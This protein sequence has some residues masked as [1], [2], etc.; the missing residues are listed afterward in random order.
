MK[1]LLTI[2]EHSPLAMGLAIAFSVSGCILVLFYSGML[3]SIELRIYDR[4]LQ[5][6]A[7]NQAPSQDITI[8]EITEQDIRN[9]GAWPMSDEVLAQALNLLLEH[10]PKVIG[11]DLYRD[12][13]VPPGS[14]NLDAVLSSDSRVIATM[15]FSEDA[16]TRIPPPEILEDSIHQV[17]FTDMPLDRDGVVRRGLLFMDEGESTHFSFPLQIA[18]KYLAAEGIVPEPDPDAPEHLRLGKETI[19][20][21]ESSDGGYVDADAGGYQFLLDY[22]GISSEF[23]SY[24]LTDLINGKVPAEAVH[25]KAVLIGVTAQSLKDFF[26]IPIDH[27]S[28]NSRVMAGVALNAHAVSQLIRFA[29]G[30]SQALTTAPNW[31]EIFWLFAWSLAG[32]FAGRRIN[33]FGRLVFVLILGVFTL[34]AITLLLFKV[35]VW[36]PVF[37]PL[38]GGITS[39]GI[40]SAIMYRIWKMRQSQL[41]A[42]FS[43]HISPELAQAMWEERERFLDNK[44]PRPQSLTATVLFTDIAGYTSISEKL[45]PPMLIEWLGK[46]MEAMT[47]AVMDNH[48]I[49]NKY[50]GDAVMAIFGVPVPSETDEEIALNAANA[51]AC[52]AAMGKHCKRLNAMWRKK[53]LPQISIR[54]GIATGELVAGPFGS[55]KRAE[56]SVIGD[57]VNTAARLESLDKDEFQIDY[58]NN[59]CRILITEETKMHLDGC[60]ETEFKGSI[61]LKG[62]ESKTD[63][64]LVNSKN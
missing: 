64:H 26:I 23:M 45:D 61:R 1:K 10:D 28:A 24:S 5:R 38:A 40:V 43:Q 50:M 30:K 6:K 36:I 7:T 4:L 53:G 56:Y 58:E 27:G 33:S 59:P 8:I 21:F 9:L 55:L 22:S 13:P 44:L 20:P 52:A 62:K 39:A 31:V 29:K 18:L 19:V 11:V 12:I 2:I 16:R 15:K 60:W 17:G 35:G 46:N 63:V 48:G 51:V 47:D 41:M 57:T 54:V 34:A 42:L 3:E 49:V 37:M 14:E 25:E 32:G